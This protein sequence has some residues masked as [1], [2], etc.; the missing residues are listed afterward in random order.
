MIRFI[1]LLI[2]CYIFYRLVKGFIF[3]APRES[4]R[5]FTQPGGIIT[6]EMV[7]DPQ[8]HVYIPKRDAYTAQVKGETLYFCSKECRKKYLNTQRN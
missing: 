8:C 5:H 3:P 6:D 2:L 7:N 1:I 4:R